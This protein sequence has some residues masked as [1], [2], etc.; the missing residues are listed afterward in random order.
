MKYE[1][2][3]QLGDFVSNLKAAGTPEQTEGLDDMI[4][5]INNERRSTPHYENHNDALAINEEL[6]IKE[7][8][9][10]TAL[11][12]KDIKFTNLDQLEELSSGS[13]L[14]R[15][16]SNDV[17]VSFYGGNL[18]SITIGKNEIEDLFEIEKCSGP[19]DDLCYR[20]TDEALQYTLDKINEN[21]NRTKNPYIEPGE[22]KM[23]EKVW[24]ARTAGNQDVYID[25]DTYEHMQ[26][27]PDVSMAHIVEA[28]GKMKDY[29]GQFRIGPKLAESKDF[30]DTHA[31]IQTSD[32]ID[33]EKSKEFQASN[34]IEAAKEALDAVK[35][36]IEDSKKHEGFT[37]S[38]GIKEQAAEM[39]DERNKSISDGAR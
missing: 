29:N 3:S 17:E 26:A 6:I 39:R 28:I 13:I 5:L 21:E 7:E 34:Q 20:I 33:W 4:E 12:D 14:P 23:F 10:H 30:W 2:L 9:E 8:I 38:L 15:Y 36:S 16:T 1:K 22:K 18:A 27:H 35:S 25:K 31:L 37:T 19:D 32:V 11:T 24:L